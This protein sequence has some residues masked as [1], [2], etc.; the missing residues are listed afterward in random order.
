MAEG[1]SL[2][3]GDR[4]S[5]AKMSKVPS[6]VMLGFVLGAL[7][8]LLFPRAKPS[9]PA[10]AAA[11]VLVAEPPSAPRAPGPLSRIEAVFERFG[12]GA[13]WSDN[14][15]E[16]A[17]WDSTTERYADFYEI[18]R[19]EGNLYFRTIPALTRRVIA[20]GKPQP[21]SPLQFTETED[22]YRE[23]YEHGR[24]E[25]PIENMWKKA[26]PPPKPL[27]V[28]APVV[29]PAAQAKVEIDLGRPG[30][31]PPAPGEARRP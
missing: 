31:P 18:R 12:E 16:V 13:V 17:M 29:V 7:S 30:L 14:V 21:D 4:P 3:Y 1:D 6:W 24:I 8:V 2:R 11:P 9:A 22:Q 10:A 5:V 28:A 25:R 27:E 26:P 23:W 15:T 20:R 19:V